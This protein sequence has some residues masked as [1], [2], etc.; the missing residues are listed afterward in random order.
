MNRLEGHVAIVSGGARGMGAATAS[1]FLA[2]GAS[3]VVG[4]ILPGVEDKYLGD[5][6]SDRFRFQHHDVTSEESWAAVVQTAT[7]SFGRIT[8]LVN[9][10]AIFDHT[11]AELVPRAVV[12][13]NMQVN[14]IGPLLGIQ[15]VIPSMREAG[16]GS[17]IN[18]AS[19][20][21]MV[22]QALGTAYGASKMAVRAMTKSA[23]LEL[24]PD[25]IRVNCVCPGVTYT[26]RHGDNQL[27]SVFENIAIQR[28]CQP[29]EIAA[30]CL[31]L[32]SDE[33]SYVTGSDLVIDGGMSAGQ[34]MRGTAHD[35]YI[36]RGA[37]VSAIGSL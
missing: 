16:K 28:I 36:A 6:P 26:I 31:Y 1:R 34:Y 24:G 23:A 30:A 7:S 17:I 27:T 25:L 15:A 37:R 12:E 10:A 22:V 9:N 32:A 13:Q 29:E 33:S 4:D 21:A 11:P 35:A 20:Q 5:A 3:V 19:A 14:Y 18:F 2:E 8:V